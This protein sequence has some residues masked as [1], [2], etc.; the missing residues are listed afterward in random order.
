[1]TAAETGLNAVQS[2]DPATLPLLLGTLDFDE[3][4]SNPLSIFSALS[5]L[6]AGITADP[7]AAAAAAAT[8]SAVVA[9]AAATGTVPDDIPNPF[10]RRLQLDLG[11][12]DLDIDTDDIAANALAASGD[13]TA[14]AN[15]AANA[16]ASAAGVPPIPDLN[17]VIELLKALLEVGVDEAKDLNELLFN[18]AEGIAASAFGPIEIFAG[19]EIYDDMNDA[20]DLF[21]DV[22]NECGNDWGCWR[23]GSEWSGTF[24]MNGLILMFTMLTCCCVGVG[25]YQPMCRQLG[26]LCMS[27]ACML[28]FIAAIMTAAVRFRPQGALCAAYHGYT[29]VPSDQIKDISDSWTFQKDGA[30]LAAMF[31]LMLLGSC[32]CCALACVPLMRKG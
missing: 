5:T 22:V 31:I 17:K 2:L 1:M 25:A 16:A 24:L 23:R 11:D 20:I 19:Q 21:T 32:L 12:L 8:A 9:N 13:L 15:A 28:N 30:F 10:G 7:A 18:L 26:A 27:V 14:A 4:R 29:S 3:L 6:G